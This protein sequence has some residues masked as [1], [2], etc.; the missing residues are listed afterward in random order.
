MD[1][2]SNDGS[3]MFAWPFNREHCRPLRSGERRLLFDH[4][5]RLPEQAQHD[6]FL[7]FV[8]ESDLLAHVNRDE[9]EHETIGWFSKGVLRGAVE[10]F[11]GDR[12]AEAALA[13]EPR[14]RGQGVG[15]ELAGR[16]LQRAREKRMDSLVILGQRGSY[17][18]L[19]I[20]ARLGAMEAPARAH[21]VRGLLPIEHPQ[22]TGFYFDLRGMADERRPGLLRRA[23]SPLRS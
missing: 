4:L 11:Y 12:D 5:R 7:T 2:P 9:P 3:T 21:V 16:A 1:S 8:D 23:F 22:A 10:I 20:A 17:P 6:R 18:A 15:T 19:A 13:V 14:W